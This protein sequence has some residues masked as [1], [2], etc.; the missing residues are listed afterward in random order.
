MGTAQRTRF[1]GFSFCGL[2]YNPGAPRD[3]EGW[4]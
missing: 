3:P 2:R 1:G 4:Q